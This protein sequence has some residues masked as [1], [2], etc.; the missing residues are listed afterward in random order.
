[1]LFF[2]I[3][4]DF[5]MFF[6]Y[7]IDLFVTFFFKWFFYI[8]YMSLD[9]WE[10]YIFKK[11]YEVRK[12]VVRSKIYKRENALLAK[13]RSDY[14]KKFANSFEKD[15]EN[16]LKY[17]K[18]NYSIIY[19]YYK[20]YSIWIPAFFKWF[21]FSVRKNVPLFFKHVDNWI[22]DILIG[23]YFIY[24]FLYIE[25]FVLKRIQKLF[26]KIFKI[27]LFV[28]DNNWILFYLF[29]NKFKIIYWA[30]KLR[31]KSR[32]EFYRFLYVNYFFFYKKKKTLIQKEFSVLNE[33]DLIKCTNQAISLT[34]NFYSFNFKF[35]Y[36][37]HCYIK[38]IQYITYLEYYLLNDI[39]YLQNN[40]RDCRI[41]IPFSFI[42]IF[43]WLSRFL[44]KF[45][46]IFD[47]YYVKYMAIIKKYFLKYLFEISSILSYIL[48]PFVFFFC[49]Y[50]NLIDFYKFFSLFV[51]LLLKK[52]K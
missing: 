49:L 22:A 44:A 33:G 1:L 39:K 36:F 2:I 14:F 23:E 19:K 43:N 8:L 46:P 18:R 52:L 37:W 35:I 48:S 21:R 40:F 51:K 45:I 15:F 12:N 26:L 4:Y 28:R 41:L 24:R 9:L 42:L 25:I 50:K 16:S 27:Y 29:F 38:K 11:I 47:K 32:R 7:T 17:D 6:F 3:I 34:F 13:K 5:F 31:K 20:Y 10:T 30:Y